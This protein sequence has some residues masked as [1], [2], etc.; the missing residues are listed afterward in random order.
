MFTFTNFE[1]VMDMIKIAFHNVVWA[2]STP[3]R[4]IFKSP[5]KHVEHTGMGS[6]TC[7]FKFTQKKKN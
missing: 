6:K 4:Y 3:S 7:L 2:P 5:L 1:F